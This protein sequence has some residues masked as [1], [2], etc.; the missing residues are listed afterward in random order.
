MSF[1]GRIGDILLSGGPGEIYPQIVQKIRQTVPARGYL[2]IGT[3]GD[4]LGYIIAPLE[5]YPEPLRRGFFD[6]SPPP[7][8][9]ADCTGGQSPVAVPSPVGCPAPVDNDNYFFNVSHTLGERL[10]CSI[11]RGAGELMK[12]DKNAYWAQ[13][14]RCAAFANDY[15]LP[16][17][18][19]TTFP[20]Q[21][22]LSGLPTF[23]H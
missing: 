13:Y 6:G 2:T 23:D 12:N 17:D 4:F 9:N 20:A 5:S 8:G 14:D 21:P 16:A 22:D 1:S 18:L 3:A 10:T 7:V 11:L 19:D 15:A